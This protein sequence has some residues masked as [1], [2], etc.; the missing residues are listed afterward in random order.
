M[1]ALYRSDSGR[2]FDDG[3]HEGDGQSG[4]LA[5]CGLLDGA[6]DSVSANEP[7]LESIPGVLWTLQATFSR[8]RDGQRGIGH[9]CRLAD[10][11]EQ[12]VAS[13]RLVF[14]P[15]QIRVVVGT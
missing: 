9:C 5:S 13:G 4:C 8:G 10:S 7:R 11:N 6:W 15:E 12:L 3:K 14:I 2:H 1:D